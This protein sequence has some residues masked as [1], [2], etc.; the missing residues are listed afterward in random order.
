MGELS[1]GELSCNRF[2][3][4]TVNYS[5]EWLFGIMQD[6]KKQRRIKKKT[7]VK[8]KE[9]NFFFVIKMCISYMQ[10][11][12][13]MICLQLINSS[14]F[15]TKIIWMKSLSRINFTVG[16]TSMGWTNPREVTESNKLYSRTH[17]NGLDKPKRGHWVK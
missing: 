5:V 11:C 12:D 9:V 17:V 2:R 3:N 8:K 1:L 14:I 10:K 4:L 7:A 13:T 6:E 16:H 15:F